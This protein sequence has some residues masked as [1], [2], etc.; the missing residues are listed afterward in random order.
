MLKDFLSLAWWRHTI[1]SLSMADINQRWAQIVAVFNNPR[2]NPVMFLMILAVILIAVLILVLTVAMIASA[3]SHRERYVLVDGEDTAGEELSEES[4]K[5]QAVHRYRRSWKAWSTT[6]FV[7]GGALLVMICV[8][9]STS[10]SSYCKACHGD[11]KKVAVMQSGKH[12]KVS[13][14]KCHESGGTL[15]RYT[16]NSIQ[17]VGHLLTGFGS[18][19]PTGYSAVPSS[20]CL[21]CHNK[22]ATGT[23]VA[24]NLGANAIRM[25]HQQPMA[26]SM[27]CSRCHNMTTAKS[28]VASAGTMNKC[29]ICHNG[30]DASDKC[31]T[32]H[33]NTPS[34]TIV[35]TAPSPKNADKLLNTDPR[36]KCY[37][38][39]AKDAARCDGCH[40][41]RIPHPSDFE[42]THP[43]AVL[44]SGLNT[45]LRCHKTTGTTA[46]PPAPG[47]A[48]S[49]TQCHGQDAN[50]RWD[51]QG[52]L[53]S[54][55]GRQVAPITHEVY[56]E[57]TGQRIQVPGPRR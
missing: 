49:C 17:R 40:G 48:G 37:T 8:G 45:C 32:C 34:K 46:P 2:I 14:V 12:S 6:L 35:A 5:A 47:R 22:T 30:T 31:S 41:L 13:C 20:A 16:V 42:S 28:P 1:N 21:N 57:E 39:H 10:T 51:F 52:Y 19:Q 53:D 55:G 3:M 26:A 43:S 50:G 7:I 56:I 36:A 27:Q 4:V 54:G 24:T 9:A 29:L 44:R 25:S 38:C 11:D 15:A 33:V 23:L 18:S